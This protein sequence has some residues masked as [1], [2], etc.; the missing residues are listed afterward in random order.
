M[1]DVTNPPRLS[2]PKLTAQPS[3]IPDG[4]LM[5]QSN[6]YNTPCSCR[7]CPYILAPPLFHCPGCHDTYRKKTLG[8]PARCAHC[9]FDFSAWLRRNNFTFTTPVFQ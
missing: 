4:E 1:T 6:P 9:N 2:P 7:K 8:F 3:E 5:I